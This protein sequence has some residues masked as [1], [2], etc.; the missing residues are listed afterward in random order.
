MT[1][2][3]TGEPS[4]LDIVENTEEED[5]FDDSLL[6]LTES[7]RRL[8]NKFISHCLS[9][10]QEDHTLRQTIQ[11]NWNSYLRGVGEASSVIKLIEL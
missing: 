3:T 1:V 4:E 11:I 9:F 2:S 7:N 6:Q 5:V 10:L 8:K